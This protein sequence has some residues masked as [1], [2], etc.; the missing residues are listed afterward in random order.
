MSISSD[1]LF[2]NTCVN[3]FIVNTADIVRGSHRKG[4]WNDDGR[5]RGCVAGP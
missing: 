2:F 1:F 5:T 4:D 3:A